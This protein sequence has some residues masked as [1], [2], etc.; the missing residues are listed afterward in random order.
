MPTVN[1]KVVDAVQKAFQAA[2]AATAEH[3]RKGGDRDLC[4]FAWVKITPARGPV[5][6]YLKQIGEGRTDSYAG[7]FMVWNPSKN[8]TQAITAKEVGADA[9]AEVL[10]KELGVNA[11]AG[12]RLD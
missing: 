7:G 6:A 3:L 8:M 2:S 9:F 4:G 5:V 10:R 12:S 1:K 11:Y